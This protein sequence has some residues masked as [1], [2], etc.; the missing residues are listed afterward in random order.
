MS[1]RRRATARRVPRSRRRGRRWLRRVTLLVLAL[2]LVVLGLRSYVVVSF[3]VPSRSMADTLQ[4]GDHIVVDRLSVRWN[5]VRRGE[6]VVFDGTAAFETPGDV[7]KRVIGIGGDRI[8]CCDDRGRL[9]VNG[10]VLDERSYLVPGDR[11]SQL[12]FDV[13]VPAGRLWVMGD[14]RSDSRDSRAYLGAPGGGSVPVSDVV[15]RVVGIAWPQDRVGRL[16]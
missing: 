16:P 15:G 1:G 12:Q 9:T 13:E 6:V 8:T 7:V 3:A 5:P 10:Q 2:S 4:V 14:H 11:P